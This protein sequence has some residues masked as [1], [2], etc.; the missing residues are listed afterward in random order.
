MEVFLSS[1]LIIA[2]YC[3]TLG[4][5]E[6]RCSLST[7]LHHEIRPPTPRSE[8]TVFGVTRGNIAELAATAI[9]ALLIV[10]VLLSLRTIGYKGKQSAAVRESVNPR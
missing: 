10:L 6:N 3:L 2:G 4:D 1:A 7:V 5:G 9:V 8:A